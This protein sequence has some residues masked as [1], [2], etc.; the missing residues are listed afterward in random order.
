MSERGRGTSE[1]CEETDRDEMIPTR[2]GWRHLAPRLLCVGALAS[3]G[4]LAA[5]AIA[6]AIGNP[7]LDALIIGTPEP[8]WVASPVQ[9]T[10]ELAS[11]NRVVASAQAG[12]NAAGA[13]KVWIPPDNGG[14]SLGVELLNFPGGIPDI[15]VFAARNVCERSK[16]TSVQSHTITVVANATGA[17][18]VL[19]AN[20][21]ATVLEAAKGTYV[22]LMFG[23]TPVNGQT[24]LTMSRLDTLLT[25][26]YN[27]LPGGG[28]S[29]G[30]IL[31]IIGILAVLIAG[32]AVYASRRRRSPVPRFAS[33]SSGSRPRV[34]AT[35]EPLATTQDYGLAAEGV[36]E[37]AEPASRSVRTQAPPDRYEP[38]EEPAPA[39]E[40]LDPGWYP[41][42]AE[43]TDLSYWDG[44]AFISRRRWD[45][46]EWQEV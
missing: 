22:I 24:P 11:L 39:E 18:C 9:Q 12:T 38:V 8:G 7:Q 3:V 40:E 15:G 17:T 27:A 44:Q 33:T 14:Q 32:G 21:G 26:Q 1:R 4:L 36:R 42:N 35:R 25:D 43:Q 34:I 37:T 31:I 19:N 10:T 46:S 28:S 23:E 41:N 45:G 30:T 5:P 20:T 16:G 2:R 13:V 6:S 29:F